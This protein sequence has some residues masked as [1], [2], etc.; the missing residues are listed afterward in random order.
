[1]LK[2]T[3]RQDR[4]YYVAELWSKLKTIR[5]DKDMPVIYSK[6]C[7]QVMEYLMFGELNND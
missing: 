6:W 7:E 5:D 3:I 4:R 2:K 1:M